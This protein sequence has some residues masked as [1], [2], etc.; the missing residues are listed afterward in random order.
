MKK[1]IDKILEA[2][3]IINKKQRKSSG[4]FIV[5]STQVASSISEEF[6]Y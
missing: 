2:S 4:N 5:T 1:L 6:F 3:N